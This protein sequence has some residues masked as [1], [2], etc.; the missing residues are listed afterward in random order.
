MNKV[1]FLQKLIKGN[2]GV[3]AAMIGILLLALVGFGS[4]AIDIGQL[5]VVRNALQ[6]SADA[7]ALAAAS[8][9]IQNT[10][11]GAVVNSTAASQ[12]AI[13][14]AQL[15]S[16]ASGQ[17]SVANGARNDITITFGTWNIYAG[18]SG[19]WTLTSPVTNS[20]N[21][22]QVTITRASGTVYGP[23]TN[24]FA[25]VFG[26]NTSQVTA[27]AIAY[28]G[29]I[30]EAKTGAVQVPLALPENILAAANAT[31]RKHWLAWALGPKEAVATT[32]KTLIFM[33]TGGAN[34]A[35]NVPTS[36]VA[37][38]DSTQ[39]Y[40]YTGAPNPGTNSIPDTVWDTLEKIYTPSLTGTSSTP[41][42]VP[43]TG[44]TTQL[45]MELSII[46]CLITWSGSKSRP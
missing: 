19:A 7:A 27:S 8:A 32:T 23:V 43:A 5:C 1:R 22:A 6:N 45:W 17:P 26:I 20:T 16:Q 10:G 34:V 9:L 46:R 29:Y 35:S 40:W 25:A 11:S 15:Q 4:L 21:A 44:R 33:D 12:A 28:I 31:G 14:V 38:L 42:L 37:N 3:S 2:D 41:V 18:G 24:L 39:P 30:N 36:P 13:N